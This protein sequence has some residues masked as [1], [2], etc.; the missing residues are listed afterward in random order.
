MLR[1]RERTADRE[2]GS[3]G[4]AERSGLGQRQVLQRT[5]MRTFTM[6]E[7]LLRWRRRREWGTGVCGRGVVLL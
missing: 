6:R 1:H 2:E 5:V 7:E 3:A 4:R